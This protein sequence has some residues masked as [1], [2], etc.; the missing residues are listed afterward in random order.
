MEAAIVM[1]GFSLVVVGLAIPILGDADLPRKLLASIVL[2]ALG[3]YCAIIGL[4][5]TVLYQPV[6]P[7]MTLSAAMAFG[8]VIA[9]YVAP[10]IPLSWIGRYLPT[11]PRSQPNHIIGAAVLFGS[12]AAVLAVTGIV[13]VVHEALNRIRRSSDIAEH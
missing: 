2:S 4:V 5:R 1:I 10:G 6:R 8:G 9:L 11:D 3:A 13:L 12:F 7:P